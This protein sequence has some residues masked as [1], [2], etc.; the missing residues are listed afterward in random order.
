[1]SALPLSD[2]EKKKKPTFRK[3]VKKVI[4]SK[5]VSKAD[6]A[7]DALKNAEEILKRINVRFSHLPLLKNMPSYFMH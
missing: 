1:M 5:K 6:A 3:A 7:L 4:K 2:D